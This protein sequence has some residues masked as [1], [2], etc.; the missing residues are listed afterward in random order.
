MALHLK[1]DLVRME[2]F[3]ARR[4]SKFT[5]GLELYKEQVTLK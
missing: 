4:S 5:F 2:A 3:V 1:V